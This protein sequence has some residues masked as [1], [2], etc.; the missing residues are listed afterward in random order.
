MT[1]IEEV[2]IVQHRSAAAADEGEEAADRP[3]NNNKSSSSSSSNTNN[4]ITAELEGRLLR[5][6][7]ETARL[8]REAVAH[9]CQELRE[10]ADLVADVRAWQGERGGSPE[11]R[12]DTLD[13]VRLLREG[14]TALRKEVREVGL[15]TTEL[16][17]KVDRCIAL[18]ET[19]LKR[20]SSSSSISNGPA[21][22]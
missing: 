19:L 7:L 1:V 8:A 15:E 18:M 6:E 5:L 22:F 20:S 14:Q 9:R 13:E 16:T 11:I 17:L 4:N 3:H 2:V 12:L 10:Y 21:R